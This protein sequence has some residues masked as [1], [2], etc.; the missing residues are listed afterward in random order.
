MD[1]QILSSVLLSLHQHYLQLCEAH[2]QEQIAEKTFREYVKD[3]DAIREATTELGEAWEWFRD[4]ERL[5]GL[6]AQDSTVT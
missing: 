4:R 3:I 6:Q 2:P 5:V 1:A